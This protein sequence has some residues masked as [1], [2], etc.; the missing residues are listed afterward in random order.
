MSGARVDPAAEQAVHQKVDDDHGGDNQQEE[1]VLKGQRDS[2]T[3]REQKAQ[4]GK[5]LAAARAALTLR[6]PLVGQKVGQRAGQRGQDQRQPGR[7]YGVGGHIRIERQRKRPREVRGGD[8]GGQG[9]T[10]VVH[11]NRSRRSAP[12]GPGQH[13]RRNQAVN[14]EVGRKVAT[15]QRA[16]K[17]RGKTAQQ[18]R[19]GERGNEARG[20]QSPPGQGGPDGLCGDLRQS[21]AQ[22]AGQHHQTEQQ[23]D[24]G[25][26]AARDAARSLAGIDGI[27]PA[28]GLALRRAAVQHAHMLYT[29]G[30]NDAARAAVAHPAHGARLPGGFAHQPLHAQRFFFQKTLQVADDNQQV[31]GRLRRDGAGKHRHRDGRRHARVLLRV[32]HD[33]VR[34]HRMT[35]QGEL[36]AGAGQRQGVV[37]DGAGLF[38]Q[39][40]RGAADF[41]HVA[42]QRL[43]V[44]AV[45]VIVE[46][47]RQVA[48]ARQ[49][50]GKGLH[51]LL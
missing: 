19:R 50:Q 11:G 39:L 40:L 23:R 3:Q 37:G 46:G 24:D 15:D 49:A 13:Q 26:A 42:A 18:Q 36:A 41:G 9:E 14:E 27:Q 33:D 43:R 34:G 47:H 10:R 2:D 51:Q 1:Q 5:Q 20:E 30:K 31:G 12:R 22:G 35:E 21:A 28:H 25:R 38:Q 45:P 29:F 48:V 6:Q 17:I 44:S 7:R 32:A 16:H 4:A 8:S